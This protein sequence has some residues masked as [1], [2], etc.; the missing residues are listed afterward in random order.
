IHYHKDQELYTMHTMKHITPA[1]ATEIMNDPTWTRAVFLR[2]PAER[3]LSCY[4]DK[5]VHRK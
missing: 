4:L 1:R 2:D 5:L 3:L